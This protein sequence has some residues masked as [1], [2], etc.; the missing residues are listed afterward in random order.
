M[1]QLAPDAK[2]EPQVFANTN[3]DAFAPPT[4]MLMMPS[5][6]FP[7][8]VNITDCDALDVPTAWSP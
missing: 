7:V 4:S 2:L 3:E 8:L 1:V 6:P 5:G